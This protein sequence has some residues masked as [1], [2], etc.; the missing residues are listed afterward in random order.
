MWYKHSVKAADGQTNA[1]GRTKVLRTFRKS[2]RWSVESSRP[3]EGGIYEHSE[4]VADGH[5]NAVGHTKV[6]Q[7]FR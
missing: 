4:K 6:L 5:R 7:T 1:V 2:E 3:L